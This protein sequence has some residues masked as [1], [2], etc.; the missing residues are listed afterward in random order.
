MK[1]FFYLMGLTLVC[2][3]LMFSACKKEE[4][5]D[6]ANNNGGNNEQPQVVEGIVPTGVMSAEN[7]V[8]LIDAD[9]AA[10]FR[11]EGGFSKGTDVAEYSEG[12][13]WK[14]HDTTYWY[15]SCAYT[16]LDQ[17]RVGLP[18][19]RS[20]FYSVPAENDM[21]S[22]GT[23]YVELKEMMTDSTATSWTAVAEL[24]GGTRNFVDDTQGKL[25]FSIPYKMVNTAD[26]SIET[27]VTV[28]IAGKF[29]FQFDADK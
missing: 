25:S 3:A 18:Y 6:D 14:S 20:L 29:N 9:T 16:I 11:F 21:V 17:E 12:F 19:L 7:V 26:E 4:S 8:L 28:M 2:G 22:F 24:E 27:K 1:K 15:Y 23:K 13:Y 10:G 5:T